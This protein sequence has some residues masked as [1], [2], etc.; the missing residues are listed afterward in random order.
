MSS[1]QESSPQAEIERLLWCLD[2]GEEFNLYFCHYPS[3][4]QRQ[5]LVAEILA[6]YQQP[7]VEI[8]LADLNARYDFA[9]VAIDEALRQELADT[10][11]EVAVFIYGLESLL[12]SA[13]ALQ[14]ARRRKLQ[15]LNWRRSE[16]QKLQRSLF[17][18]LPEYALDEL[19]QYAP[20]FF[21]WNSGLF[22]F[23]PKPDTLVQPEK[24]P[25]VLVAPPQEH[26]QLPEFAEPGF[27]GRQAELAQIEQAW[28]A[29]PR[30]TISGMGGQG[31]TYLALAVA[32]RFLAEG[33][34]AVFVSYRGFQGIDPT[35]FAVST[36][37][38][39]LQVSLVDAQAAFNELAKQATL[40]ILDQVET[41]RSLRLGADELDET[42]ES[43]RAEARAPFEILLDTAAQWSNNS[44]NIRI[45]VTTRLSD[46][47]HPAYVHTLPLKGFAPTDALAWFDALQRTAP[48]VAGLPELSD[49]TLL[50]LF[51][52]VAYHP[53]AISLLGKTLQYL[54]ADRLLAL[55]PGDSGAENPLRAGLQ[56][57][58]TG[59][60]AQTQALLPLFSVFVGGAWEPVIRSATG[61][62]S[63]DWQSLRRELL[64]HG[65]LS[66]EKIPP[67]HGLFLVF[68]PALAEA[69]RDS[70]ETTRRAALQTTWQHAYYKLSGFLYRLDIKNPHAARAVARRE[71]PNLLAAVNAA[72]EAKD[73]DAVEF[74]DN[75]N[76]F[77]NYFGLRREHERLAARAAQA[78]GARGSQA[79]VVARYGLGEQLRNAGRAA[80]AQTVFLDLLDGL[81]GAPSY[82]RC[83][84]LG[85]LGRCLR[86]QGQLG[87]AAARYRQK[88]E[89][90]AVL[91]RD[92]ISSRDGISGQLKRQTGIAHTDLGDVLTDLGDYLGA[93]A[94]YE[95]SLAIKHEIGDTRG[96][97]VTEGQL[98]TLALQQGQLAEAAQRYQAALGIFRQLNELGTEAVFHH[99]LGV[100][101]QYAQQWDAAEQAYRE[102]AR[103]DESQGHIQGAAQ[104]W[105]QLA[106]VTASAGKAA[107]AEGWYHKAIAGSQAARDSVNQARSL[108][109]L[110]ALLLNL[111]QKHRLAE[112]RQLAEQALAIDETLDPVGAEIW[113]TYEILARIAEREDKPEEAADW[114][115]KRKKM[116]ES[117]PAE[118]R[119]NL[120]LG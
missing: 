12:P 118:I 6:A 27:V 4:L 52:K 50:R 109:N 63:Q 35:G 42:T 68:H 102:S 80:Q 90:L 30:L 11:P 9:V 111:N 37:G 60:S 103:L 38:A 46:V 13:K 39:S 83:V 116:I 69:L 70:L 15:Q 98:G 16:F 31:K 115:A 33:K 76:Q 14:D 105:N 62:S 64:H 75:V 43:S 96:I 28:Q 53:Q 32:R 81:G 79:W 97:A 87:A 58:M 77:L 45:L 117:L 73:A 19:A 110:A 113:K 101:Y 59:L 24:Q 72:L 71:L 82:Q 85:M 99:Q 57:A 26:L 106:Q 67:A 47:A 94:A 74:A 95:A 40:V 25:P 36:I 88:L 3:P 107:E 112:A 91:Q 29:A 120:G 104:A 84:T 61:L 78:G 1:P 41:L 7:L 44:P 108:N 10:A 51:A 56:L 34:R 65:L 119:R 17:F 8:D 22:E 2:A 18:W 86:V 21:D 66:E 20:D 92:A 93:R 23:A 5:Q 89:D 54:E 100:T 48:R 114:R 49:D 55:L